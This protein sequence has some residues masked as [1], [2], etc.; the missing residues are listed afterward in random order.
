MDPGVSLREFRDD[1]EGITQPV[2]MLKD[3]Y[4]YILTNKV[5]GTLYIGVT[6][7]LRQRVWQH[8]EH[9]VEGFTNRYNLNLLVWF[10]Q[11]DTMLSAIAKEKVMKRWHRQWKIEL[12]ETP[13]PTW[14]DLFAEL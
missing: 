8:Q 4:V 7:N 5:R 3:P 13:N 1:G 11:H 2:A 10:E 12:I 6:S 9:L 14:R